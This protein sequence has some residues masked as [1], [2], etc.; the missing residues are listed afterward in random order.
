M[1][2]KNKMCVIVVVLVTLLACETTAPT[3]KLCK[4]NMIKR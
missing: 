4:F 2:L 3:N 1:Q